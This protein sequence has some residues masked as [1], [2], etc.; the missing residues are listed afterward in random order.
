LP[1]DRY[2]RENPGEIIDLAIKK[3]GRFEP[4]GHRVTGDH[5]GQ[6]TPRA[7]PRARK[8]GGEGWEYV[9]IAI[10]DH[11]RRSFCQIHPDE[12]GREC[13][14]H[15]KAA[16]A[17]YQRLAIRGIAIMTDKGPCDRSMAF[18]KACEQLGIKHL[19]TK[20]YSPQTNAKAERF[21]Q[22]A[23]REWAYARPYQTSD[24]RAKDLPLWAHLY[25]WHRPH[26]GIKHKT[27]ISRLGLN[28][29][30]LLRV[31]T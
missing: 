2:E 22:P 18:A 15:L 11:S 4:P 28:R 1:I 16:V 6:S 8:Q 7:T 31:H 29:D 5:T 3:L 26:G 14:R 12:K 24:Q 27:P 30:N 9:H 17:Y 13:H 23:L 20:A 19:R 21:I 10:D 25:N